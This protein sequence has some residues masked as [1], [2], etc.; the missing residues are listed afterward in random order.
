M[1]RSDRVVRAEAD[2]SRHDRDALQ[3]RRSKIGPRAS[4][5]KARRHHRCS[6]P[7]R[8]APERNVWR[9]TARGVSWCGT[10][11]PCFQIYSLGLERDSNPRLSVS[12]PMLYPSE[13]SRGGRTGFEPATSA[14]AAALPAELSS[15][16]NT[17]SR[18]RAYATAT[19]RAP[20]GH[21]NPYRWKPFDRCFALAPKKAPILVRDPIPSACAARRPCPASGHS[22]Y[23]PHSG[24]PFP[25]AVHARMLGD[26]N[27]SREI[28]V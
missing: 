14:C 22:A 19:P 28:R 25:R 7:L 21:A 2:P 13:L 9:N 16:R 11:V 23:A 6:V 18:P 1:P 8:D 15:S 10:F 20:D 17:F 3:S 5:T 12:R 4:R 26:A 27:R 24:N